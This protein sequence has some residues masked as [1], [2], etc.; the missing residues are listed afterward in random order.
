MS[1]LPDNYKRYTAIADTLN[2]L[3]L[4][5]HAIEAARETCINI[6]IVGGP[7]IRALDAYDIAKGKNETNDI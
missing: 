3:K 5:R 7:L 6:G 4:A 2:E 1:D